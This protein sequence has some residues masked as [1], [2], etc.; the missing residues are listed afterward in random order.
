MGSRG[1]FGNDPAV[2][3]MGR[4]LRGNDVG[5]DAAFAVEDGDGRF[6]ARGFDAEDD[7]A[8]ALPAARRLLA[9][10]GRQIARSV[11]MAVM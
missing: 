6:V 7:Q 8:R 3:R 11:T 10:G 1:H 5:P 2:A 9:Y 4:E